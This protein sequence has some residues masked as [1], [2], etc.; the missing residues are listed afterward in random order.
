MAEQNGRSEKP[1]RQTHQVHMTKQLFRHALS[2]ASEH[3][4]ARALRADKRGRA[5]RTGSS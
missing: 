4:L 2:P 1:K 5:A 3:L